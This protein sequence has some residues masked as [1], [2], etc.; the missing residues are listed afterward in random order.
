MQDASLAIRRVDYADAIDGAALLTLLD[1]YALDPMGGGDAL[2][3]EVKA[4][5]CQ[6]L[7]GNPAAMS[8]IAW[9]HADAGSVPIGLLNAFL[10]YSTFK[11]RP[12]LNIH[13]IIV[14]APDRGRGVGQRLLVAAENEARARGCC[15]L[16]LE[17][18]TG[19][20]P[21]MASYRR[22]G[23]EPYVLDPAAGQASLMQK[24]LTPA[25]AA[26]D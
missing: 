2:S 5:L 8:W 22:F 11:A 15:K 19:N 13:D 24:W 3:H 21:A 26:T 7:A 18:L 20:A 4:R 17:I 9:R 1:A 16:T 25:K 10:G 14:Q 23:F 12:L 6:D